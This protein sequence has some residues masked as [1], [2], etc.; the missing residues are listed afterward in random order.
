MCIWNI[1][2]II[3][4]IFAILFFTCPIIYI[5]TGK[6]KHWYHDILEWHEPDESPKWS[7]GCSLHCR[8]KYCGK[9]YY[10]R[11]SGKLVLNEE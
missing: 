9:K 10:A 3:F 4:V 2:L 6:F 5:K 11:Q 7:D 1:V 8:C